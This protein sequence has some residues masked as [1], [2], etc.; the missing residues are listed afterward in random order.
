MG[1]G[2]DAMLS[3]NRLGLESVMGGVGCFEGEFIGGWAAW[4]LSIPAV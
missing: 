2:G 3:A 1:V 4:P